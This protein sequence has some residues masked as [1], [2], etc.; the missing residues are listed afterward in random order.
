MSNKAVS[1]PTSRNLVQ[2]APSRP[3]VHA[4]RASGSIPIG[5]QLFIL[6][7]AA[8]TLGALAMI[9]RAGHPL[10]AYLVNSDAFYL[11]VLFDDLL[12]RGGRLADWYLTPAPY[13]FPDFPL[14]LLAWLLGADVFQQVAAFALLQVVATGAALFLLAR[15]ILEHDRLPAAAALSILFVWLGLHAGDPFVRLFSSAHHYGAF[16]AALLLVALWLQRDA[17]PNGKPDRR[18]DAAVA[19]LVFLSTLSDALFLVQAVLPLAAAALLCRQER[20]GGAARRAFAQ[21]LAPALAA[22]I[23]YRFLVAHPTRYKTRIGFGQFGAHFDEMSAMGSAL[24]GPRPLLAAALL[25]VLFAG[26]ACIALL[27]RGRLPARVPRP[28]ALLLA[29]ATLS[30]AATVGV[31]LLSTNVQPVPRYLI[32]ALSWPLVAGLFGLSWLL[33]RHFRHAALGLAVGCTVL[34][35]AEAWQVKDVRNAQSYYYPQQIACIDRALAAA[36]ARH[37]IAQYW[38]AKLLQG[39]SRNRLTLAQHFATLEPMQWITSERFFATRYDFAIIAEREVP[40]FRLPRARLL[41]LN[42]EPAQVVHCGDRTVLLYGAGG[43]RV[44]PDMAAP[45]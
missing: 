44:A 10:Q 42:G 14:Y 19:I 2:E 9:L 3:P 17:G 22:M 39:L 31:M 23:S 34:L 43:L 41:A 40:E 12:A 32:A 5:R 15:Q 38:D 13:F 30:C 1:R 26:A 6:A 21:L 25:L 28:V 4:P 45:R 36:G 37:G 16:V 7:C 24:F 18:L 27:L 33:R 8:V 11:P 29:F 35:A 20:F